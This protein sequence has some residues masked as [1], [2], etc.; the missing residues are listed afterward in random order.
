MNLTIYK[1]L[2]LAL[3]RLYIC[4]NEAGGLVVL[5]P[6]LY[7]SNTNIETTA[8]QNLEAATSSPTCITILELKNIGLYINGISKD[9]E[10]HVSDKTCMDT[11]CY[12]L[13]AYLR[14]ISNSLEL[15][16]YKLEKELSFTD[17][18]VESAKIFNLYYGSSLD[19]VKELLENEVIERLQ[20]SKL[21]V[22]VGEL[23]EKLKRLEDS[24]LIY[25]N[26]IKE[27]VKVHI[28]KL[29]TIRQ[30]MNL[31]GVD[32]KEICL[33]SI[34]NFIVEENNSI[35]NP[36]LSKLYDSY[37]KMM[38]LIES[39]VSYTADISAELNNKVY[40]DNIAELIIYRSFDDIK[41]Y[42]EAFFNYEKGLF[43]NTIKDLYKQIMDMLKIHSLNMDNKIETDIT[44]VFY[45]VKKTPEK[46]NSSN[47][48]DAET[49]ILLNKIKSYFIYSI[50]NDS[51]LDN[52]LS[53]KK[54]IKEVNTIFIGI[55]KSENKTF[56]TSK[57][58]NILESIPIFFKKLEPLLKSYKQLPIEAVEYNNH[59]LL[60][61][62]FGGKEVMINGNN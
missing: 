28:N 54:F 5:N 35:F 6:S 14:F 25:H 42:M 44:K 31:V 9:I 34:S 16:N 47:I 48:Q 37:I 33:T 32:I 24:S 3:Q 17:N 52:N 56:K 62:S 59:K 50:K 8:N 53:F 4:G 58:K 40:I 36:D 38:S 27:T 12:V 19:L 7:I 49:N 51:T 26:F 46:N 10:P 41:K 21:V 11:R 13:E 39:P 2:L 45:D 55:K 22:N 43:N 15:F 20:D 30:F 18:N 29:S 1:L 23:L 61:Q 57:S 60:I